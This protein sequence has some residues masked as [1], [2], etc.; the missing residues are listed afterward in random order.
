MFWTSPLVSSRIRIVFY[1]TMK[2]L[3]LTLLLFSGVIP[4]ETPVYVR[5]VVPLTALRDSESE[6][7]RFVRGSLTRLQV[8]EPAD[9]EGFRAIEASCPMGAEESAAPYLLLIPEHSSA[10]RSSLLVYLYG[11]GGSHTGYN[12]AT[13]AYAAF[14]KG[15]AHRGS[16]ILVPEL[17]PKHF[18]N[19]QAKRR[20]DSILDRVL[21]EYPIDPQRVHL[22]GTSM[23]GGSALAYAIYRP[24]LARSVCAVIPM[25]DLALWYRQAES[26]RPDL[27]RAL[28]GTPEEVPEAYASFSA[29]Y[30][31]DAF[32]RTPVFLIGAEKDD[33]VPPEHARLL[34]ER[35]S[36]K[37]YPV[38]YREAAD[39]G[40]ANE[41]FT[42]FGEEVLAFLEA[43]QKRRSDSHPSSEPGA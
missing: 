20:L 19:A 38:T 2:A 39:V 23:G 3:L 33:K 11:A 27:A 30:N 41:A 24:G 25:T 4:T 43:A 40:H 17:G 16:F 6:P 13:E 32:R 10:T 28:G 7:L 37:G 9:R 1:H 29:L 21:R 31:V 5:W 42:P 36:A 26:Y 15:L 34:A 14:R 12:L 18:M 22:M 35:L 8:R